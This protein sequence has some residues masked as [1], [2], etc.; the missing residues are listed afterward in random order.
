[1]GRCSFPL[2][3]KETCLDFWLGGE[4]IHFVTV[5]LLGIPCS[6][7]SSWVSGHSGWEFSLD[8]L[9]KFLGASRSFMLSALY[10]NMMKE[11]EQKTFVLLSFPDLGN[12]LH[13]LIVAVH[14]MP[15]SF[16]PG[17]FWWKPRF[18]GRAGSAANDGSHPGNSKGKENTSCNAL[19]PG[20]FG[21]IFQYVMNNNIFCIFF[22]DIL[23][24]VLFKSIFLCL[25]CKEFFHTSGSS[26]CCLLL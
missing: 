2:G 17:P 10:W 24:C 8:Q 6:S 4:S 3:R 19:R 11:I 5:L 13:A 16:W 25:I 23:F 15:D 14:D 20:I 26:V 7:V 1:M 9:W 21:L 22:S 18:R 12:S